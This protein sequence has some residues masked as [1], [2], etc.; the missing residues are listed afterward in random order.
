[1]S[2]SFLVLKADAKTVVS[3]GGR[4]AWVGICGLC[5]QSPLFRRRAAPPTS[6]LAVCCQSFIPQASSSPIASQVLAWVIQRQTRE[7]WPCGGFSPTDGLLVPSRRMETDNWGVSEALG[8]TSKADG[9]HHLT[10]E[11]DEQLDNVTSPTAGEGAEGTHKGDSWF[12]PGGTV[13]R[14]GRLSRFAARQPGPHGVPY[15][16]LHPESDHSPTPRERAPQGGEG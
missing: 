13:G 6:I 4:H 3:L 7:M 16:T 11:A 2:I 1:M 5:P 15:F 9:S 10:G 12:G 14:K 8:P